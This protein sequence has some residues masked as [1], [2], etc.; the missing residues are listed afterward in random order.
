MRVGP[1]AG[2]YG[3]VGTRLKEDRSHPIHVAFFRYENVFR[4]MDFGLLK[5]RCQRRPVS[6]RMRMSRNRTCGPDD[7][8]NLRQ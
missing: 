7:S 8:V 3:M 6:L 4:A 2:W 5:L 1:Y